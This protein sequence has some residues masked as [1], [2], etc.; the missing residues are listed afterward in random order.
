MEMKK[1]VLSFNEFVNEAYKIINEAE[2][3][4]DAKQKLAK[5]LDTK[6]DKA[7]GSLETLL[8]SNSTSVGKDNKMLEFVGEQFNRLIT[9][10]DGKNRK[11]TEINVAVDPI[12]NT[13][14]NRI[15]VIQGK[16]FVSKT[17]VNSGM[18]GETVV[19]KD[20][21]ANLGDL[22]STINS[23]NIYAK[24]GNSPFEYDEKS[25]TY[26]MKAEREGERKGIFSGSGTDKQFVLTD[27]GTAGFEF[28]QQNG[29]EAAAF[30]LT[31]SNAVE[32]APVSFEKR[33]AIKKGEKDSLYCT[34]VMYLI[35]SII[36]NGG[37]ATSIEKVDKVVKIV[38]GGDESLSIDIQDNGTL[39]EKS[40]SILKEEGKSNISNAILNQFT[41]VTSIEVVGGASKEGD[42][43]FNKKLCQDR[44][45]SV[46]AYLK[47]ITPAPITVSSEANIQP[48]ESTEDLK[49]WRKVTL[50]VTGTKVAQSSPTE[51]VSYVARAKNFKPD[52]ALLAQVCFEFKI[53]IDEA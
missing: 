40:K 28:S 6:G 7:L 12:G 11:I 43:A 5:L 53:E 1:Q 13:T 24:A 50:K 33:K 32:T 18:A 34:L 42:A 14:D 44:A 48:L 26:K 51:E 9:K 16:V 2:T 3:F 46:E 37:N 49:T 19:L 17:N 4:E 52:A 35:K 22:L 25:K 8:K 31:P 29:K 39:F 20:G 15:D 36:P 21:K 41:S 47:T 23:R 30:F 45:K 27:L 38:Q 10:Y